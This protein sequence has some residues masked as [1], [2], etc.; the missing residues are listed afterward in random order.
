MDVQLFNTLSRRVEHFE[1]LEPGKVTFYACGPTVYNTAHI[2][3]LRTYLF[4]DVLR[5]VLQS[6]EYTVRHVMNVTDVGHLESDADAGDDK[7][8]LA[9]KREHKSPWDIARI[10]EKEF[11]DDCAA[12][13]ILPPTVVCRATEHI[14]IMQRFVQGLQQRGY[15]YEVDGNVYYRTGKFPDYGRLRGATR[16]HDEA[17]ARVE[18]DS[19]KQDP[20]DFVLWFSN[21]KFPNQ[22][23]KWDSP[24]GVGFPGWHIECSAMATHHLGERIDIHAGGVDH[25]PVHHANEIAQSEGLLGHKWV[26]VWM[27]G[28]FLVLAKDKMAKSGGNALTLNTLRERGF[29][30]LHY[31]YLCLTVHYRKQLVFSWESLE[32]AKRGFE[33]LKNRVVSWKM[34]SRDS[35][36]DAISSVSTNNNKEGAARLLSYR[37]RF[38]AAVRDDLGTPTALATAWEMAKDPALTPAEKLALAL[39]F[40][41]VL[42]LGVEGF[43]R[44]RLEPELQAL[45][46]QRER[47]RGEKRWAEADAVRDQ[48]AQRGVR[49][50]DAPGGPDWYLS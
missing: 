37:A 21:S 30:P 11:F 1:P 25:I 46:Q 20:R 50:Q 39:E 15:T 23:M 31:R 40:D 41:Q 45:V 18:S 42:G 24:W 22:I 34:Q 9:A 43:T 6:A 5:R 13:R 2:G 14:E 35:R 4:E 32:S 16:E 33:A 8:A 19:R 47:L 49:L 38:W 48:L 28:E 44:P 36:G 29:D 17:H 10:Y 26:N 27:H 7:L 3:N 12:L